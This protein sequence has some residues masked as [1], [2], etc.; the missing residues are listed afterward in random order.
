MPE[1]GIH[2]IS[3]LLMTGHDEIIV[4]V[5]YFYDREYYDQPEHKKE[6]GED[7]DIAN[8]IASGLVVFELHRSVP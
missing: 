4:A 8:Y 1:P 5:S 6:L 7:I 3:F 2:L